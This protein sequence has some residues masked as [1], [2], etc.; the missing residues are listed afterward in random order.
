MNVEI[1]EISM[2]LGLVESRLRVDL[3]QYD[4]KQSANASSP[5]APAILLSNTT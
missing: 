3:K 2:I 1:G 5:G 4:V